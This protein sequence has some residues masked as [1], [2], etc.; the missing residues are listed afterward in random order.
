MSITPS[1]WTIN[2][3]KVTQRS[4]FEPQTLSLIHLQ[5]WIL[6]IKLFKKK[7]NFYIIN[8]IVKYMFTNKEI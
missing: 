8:K 6:A 5:K 1:A 3:Y 2:C 4:K 7:L